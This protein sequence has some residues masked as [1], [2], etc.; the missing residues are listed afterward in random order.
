[1]LKNPRKRGKLTGAAK[2]AFLARMTK[3][4]KKAGSQSR[5]TKA[6][7]SMSGR[8]AQFLKVTA[9]FPRPAKRRTKRVRRRNLA[10]PGTAVIFVKL[11]HKDFYYTNDNVLSTSRE[12]ARRYKSVRLAAQV[13]RHLSRSLPR[14]QISINRP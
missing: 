2:A 4:R 14:A 13:A 10:A 5:A 6:R 3:G 12:A 7:R 1:M 11:G 9:Q 8:K